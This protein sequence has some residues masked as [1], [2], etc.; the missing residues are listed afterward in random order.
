MDT[1]FSDITALFKQ[2]KPLD[3]EIYN[4][5]IKHQAQLTKPEKSLGRLEELACWYESVRGKH[6]A[7]LNIP[8]IA[9]FAGNHGI[10]HQQQISAFPA[11]V[12][13]A[14]LQNFQ[15]GGAAINQIAGAVDADFVAYDLQLEQ[16]TKDFTKE[17]AMTEQACAHAISYGMMAIDD[18]VDVI[19]PGEMGIGN[20]ASA[21]AI[22]HA[23]YGGKAK[24]WVGRGTGVDDVIYDNKVSLI[25]KSVQLHQP[26]F[27]GDYRSLEIL[28]HLGGFE[29]AAMVGCIMAARIAKVA[30]ILDG[31]VSC[32]AAAILHDIDKDYINHCIV[33]HVSAEQAHQY[34][35]KKIDKEPILDLNMR[36]GEA[37]G[38]ATAIAILK[39]ALACHHG[40]ASFADA[41]VS[42]KISS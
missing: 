11:D 2:F 34:V 27:Q 25:K 39:I 29:I 22:Y 20:T 41:A 10:A 9:V 24:D 33:G 28:R 26:Y 5:A 30:V 1:T 16:P 37:S 31:F 8:R 3:K 17:P 38:G 12:T 7:P 36:L 19:V 40:M 23:L 6:P 35:L 18:K 4:Q 15:N 14:M 32:A 21:A 42:E 13:I